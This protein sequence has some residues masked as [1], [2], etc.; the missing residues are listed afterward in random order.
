MQAVKIHYI[1][2]LAAMMLVAKPFVGF[3]ICTFKDGDSKTQISAKAFTK[4]KQ[5]YIENSEY[6]I[7][8]LRDCLAHPSNPLTLLFSLLLNILFPALLAQNKRITNSMLSNMQFSIA[9]QTQRFLLTGKL[10][11]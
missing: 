10:T 4:R 9:P 1:L 6:D 8:N 2:F 11:I 5:E 3:G 7:S